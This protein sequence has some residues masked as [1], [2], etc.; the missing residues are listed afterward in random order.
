ML[1]VLL[2]STVVTV[3]ALEEQNLFL[4]QNSQETEHA[5]DELK[6]NFSKVKLAMDTK[7]KVDPAFMA[8]SL[9]IHYDTFRG[10]SPVNVVAPHYYMG[11]LPSQYS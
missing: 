6:Q 11:P 10:V 1:L 3:Q 7:M 9:T 2:R 4:I 8:C 5:L